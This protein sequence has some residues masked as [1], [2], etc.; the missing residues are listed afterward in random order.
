[1]IARE[2][3]DILETLKAPKRRRYKEARK[4]NHPWERTD[5]IKD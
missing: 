5:D 1:M 2:K 4:Q 3:D